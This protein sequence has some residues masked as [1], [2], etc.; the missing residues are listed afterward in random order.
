MI[1]ALVVSCLLPHTYSYA[2]DIK[3][4]VLDMQA[5]EKAPQAQQ[6]KKRM[7]EFV[8]PKEEKFAAEQ[9]KIKEKIEAFERNK[10]ILTEKDKHAKQK[11]IKKLDHDLA[12]MGEEFES[13]IE[14]KQREELNKFNTL[15][16]KIVND[17]ARKEKYGLILH[18]QA[19][20]YYTK[21]V[22]FTKKVL[23]ELEKAAKS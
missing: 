14:V 22:D 16:E 13:D 20:P 18:R 6:M 10:D 21:D 15:V 1:P 3:I 9:K 12:R 11:E 23:E 7:S 4:G 5:L 8:K 19:A 2:S 17:I